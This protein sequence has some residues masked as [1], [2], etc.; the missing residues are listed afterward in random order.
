MT[1]HFMQL[2]EDMV[3]EQC[4]TRIQQTTLT[5]H[6]TRQRSEPAT[7]TQKDTQVKFTEQEIQAKNS[8]QK[9]RWNCKNTLQTKPIFMD[10]DKLWSIIAQDMWWTLPFGIAQ[11][12]P[13]SKTVT[14]ISQEPN[15]ENNSIN[16]RTSIR[17]KSESHQAE[18]QRSFSLMSPLTWKQL[19]SEVTSLTSED[20]RRTERE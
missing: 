18:F 3:L 2:P 11:A 8:R 7:F 6:Q 4:Q 13:P 12:G 9:E 5:I 14:L 16:Q 15:T 1:I 20:S 17:G 10:Q 19:V